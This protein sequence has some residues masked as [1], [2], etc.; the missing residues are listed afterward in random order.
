MVTVRT[1]DGAYTDTATITVGKN[2]GSSNPGVVPGPDS[3]AG[4]GET[5]KPDVSPKPDTSPQ[6]GVSPKPGTSPQ[7][8][9]LPKPDETSKPD[10]PPETIGTP[11]PDVSPE[12]DTSPTVQPSQTPDKVSPKPVNDQNLKAGKAYYNVSEKGTAKYLKPANK[13]LKSIA[14]PATVNING[15]TYKVTSIANKAFIN[16]K[17]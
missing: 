15:V 5:P 2:D 4:P 8:G 14:V 7:P 3:P 1:N 13:N 16:K 10:V 11:E 9:I 6:P 17:N 12:P